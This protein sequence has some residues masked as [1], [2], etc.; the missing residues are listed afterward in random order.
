LRLRVAELAGTLEPT[1][2]LR[3]VRAWQLR[4]TALV[5]MRD[6]H[7]SVDFRMLCGPMQPLAVDSTGTLG[8]ALRCD[9]SIASWQTMIDWMRLLARGDGHAA[10]A[11]RLE[12]PKQRRSHES[13][14]GARKAPA[15]GDSAPTGAK[16]TGPHQH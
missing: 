6:G 13:T 8:W 12:R 14:A 7:W 16:R 15:P 1:S 3:D 10:I 4:C 9:Q 5:S 11:A 2:F